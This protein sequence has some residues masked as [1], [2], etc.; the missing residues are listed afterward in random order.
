MRNYFFN[1][2]RLV[3]RHFLTARTLARGTRGTL[4]V[5]NTSC[6]QSNVVNY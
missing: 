4:H 6:E 3:R 1:F 5:R 2:L